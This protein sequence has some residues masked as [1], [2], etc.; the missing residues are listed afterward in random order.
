MQ[1]KWCKSTCVKAGIQK[2]GKQKFKC[3]LCE[4][5]QQESYVY[6]SYCGHIREQFSRMNRMGCGPRKLSVFLGISIN[7]LQK[8]IAKAFYLQPC[9]RFEENGEYDIDE[10]QTWITNETIKFG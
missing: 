9:M 7:T 3:K 5:Y 10:L 6:A 4:K 8:W 2:T 1:C